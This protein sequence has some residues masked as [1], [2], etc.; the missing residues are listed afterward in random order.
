VVKFYLI[1]SV[2][3][4]VLPRRVLFRTT[5]KN[6]DHKLEIDWD[7]S[8]TFMVRLVLCRVSKRPWE[9]RFVIEMSHQIIK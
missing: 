2:T 9:W 6:M 7:M 5:Q 1:G 3:C 4:F 8:A